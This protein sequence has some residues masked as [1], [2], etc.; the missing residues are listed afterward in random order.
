MAGG[1]SV[2]TLS[3]GSVAT[4]SASVVAGLVSVSARVRSDRSASTPGSGLPQAASVIA[5]ALIPAAARRGIE[6]VTMD[7]TISVV[8]HALGHRYRVGVLF[9]GHPFHG[10]VAQLVEH[11]LCKQK[12]VGS[13]PIVSTNKAPG[14]EAAG[15]FLVPGFSRLHISCTLSSGCVWSTAWGIGEHSARPESTGRVVGE[16]NTRTRFR[17]NG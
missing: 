1:A 10:D 11:L 13:I 4:G 12:V 9:A 6:G 14:S 2:V 7:V 16:R 5:R 15:G 17:A 3:V 8:R